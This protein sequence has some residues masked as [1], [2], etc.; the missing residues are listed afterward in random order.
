ME[1]GFL[2][3]LWAGWFSFAGGKKINKK[4]GVFEHLHRTLILFDV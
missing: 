3:R 4:P 2:S 1:Q